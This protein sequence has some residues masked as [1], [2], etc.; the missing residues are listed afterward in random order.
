MAGLDQ[1]FICGNCRKTF[2]VSERTEFSLGFK[3]ASLI[4]V[5][6]WFAPSITI[7]P[8]DICHSCRFQVLLVSVCFIALSLL[9]LSSAAIYFVQGALVS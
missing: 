5:I 8:Q 7:W 1:P 4:A 2:N 3:I 9:V 6:F